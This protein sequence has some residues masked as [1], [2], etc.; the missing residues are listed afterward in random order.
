MPFSPN[1][2]RYVQADR[3]EKRIAN[4]I[5][6]RRQREANLVGEFGSDTIYNPDE[7]SELSML[8]AQKE[9]R[10]RIR[11]LCEGRKLADCTSLVLEDLI[12]ELTTFLT[13]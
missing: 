3:E 5:L 4:L 10:R 12:R 11:D 7:E 2:L 1:S 8:Q 9:S 13:R 6:G